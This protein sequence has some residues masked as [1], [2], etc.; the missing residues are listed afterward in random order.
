MEVAP[1]RLLESCHLE[2]EN[3]HGA[4]ATGPCSPAATALVATHREVCGEGREF[5]CHLIDAGTIGEVFDP[6]RH[7]LSS[8]DLRDPVRVRSFPVRVRMIEDCTITPY[9][10][11]VNDIC[12][13]GGFPE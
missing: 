2:T 3:Q 1:T 6:A 13:L 9:E 10:E 7:L 4:S 5:F 8:I 12:V 11:K